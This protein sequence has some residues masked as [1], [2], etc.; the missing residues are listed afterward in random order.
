M[1]EMQRDVGDRVATNSGHRIA[2]AAGSAGAGAIVHVAP[3]GGPLR[4]VPNNVL[5]TCRILSTWGWRV[6]MMTVADAPGAR[7]PGYRTETFANVLAR[8]PI[9][10]KFCVSPS[11]A[12]SLRKTLRDT[13]VVHAHG[14]WLLPSAHAANGARRAGK[15]YMISP[16][17][18]LAP[19]ALKF[20]IAQK[21]IFWW[22]HQRRA[23]ER[24]TCLHAASEQEYRDIRALGLKTPVAIIPHGVEPPAATQ[25][26]R[27]ASGDRIVLSLGRLHPIKG[28]DLL[29]AAWARIEKDHPGWRLQ[30]AG[31]SE[32]DYESALRGL[33][34]SAGL[35]RIQF[36]GPRIGPE[37]AEIFAAASLF[38]L[39][40]RSENFALTVP[41]ALSYCVPV[42][43][44]KGTPWSALPEKGCGWWVGQ[45]VEALA[46]ALAR[47]M[48]LPPDELRRM[49]ER[50]RDWVAEEFTWEGIVRRL[51]AVY[52]WMRGDADAPCDLRF[53]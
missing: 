45:D 4:D 35:A 30:I 50:G 15:P 7:H 39:P 10:A 19:E 12:L 43:A 24:A 11:L 40:S 18:M 3:T 8:A 22:A 28:L 41:E 5:Q 34:A 21:R 9:L 1:H 27:P 2:T 49:G 44:S 53:E 51:D 32:G 33:A 17:G 46:A 20:G 14:L 26:S 23:L 16:H 48:R 13:D 25:G 47:A 6:T 37:K 31:P 42:I 52:R 36:L 38:A 29:I